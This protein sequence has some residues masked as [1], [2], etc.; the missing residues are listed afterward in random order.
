ML[1]VVGVVM[2]CTGVDDVGGMML[3]DEDVVDGKRVLVEVATMRVVDTDGVE[4]VLGLNI[5][6]DVRSEV[7]VVGVAE[8]VGVVCIVGDG[9]E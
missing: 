7:R 4:T 5:G 8:V 6:V 9:A 3:V 2:I 1:G